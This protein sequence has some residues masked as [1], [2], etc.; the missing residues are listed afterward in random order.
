MT[1]PTYNS[2]QQ[3]KQR[4]NNPNHH[5]YQ[6]YGGRGITYDP[7]WDDYA[8]FRQDMGRRPEGLTLDR[9]DNELGYSKE[10][11]RWATWEEQASNKRMLKT[12]T[13]GIKGVTLCRRTNR[14]RAFGSEKGKVVFLYQG[15]SFDKALAARQNWEASRG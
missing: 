4:C 15:T 8:Q 13:S 12:N 9:I 1:T 11:C 2:W 6:D 3:M 14:W 5:Q 10:N 7:S